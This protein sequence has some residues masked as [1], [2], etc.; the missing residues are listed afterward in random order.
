MRPDVSSRRTEQGKWSWQQGN[1]AT[2]GKQDSMEAHD[3][4][5]CKRCCVSA[6]QLWS[7]LS[8]DR[9]C[10]WIKVQ[11]FFFILKQRTFLI[12]Q[13]EWKVTLKANEKRIVKLG[14]CHTL[15]HCQ[16]ESCSYHCHQDPGRDTFRYILFVVWSSK[17]AVK[18]QFQWITM[19]TKGELL[20]SAA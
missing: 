15:M 18:R 17:D 5:G 16:G 12:V 19:S 1:L 11:D 10:V 7:D 6:V 8:V 4:H 9:A 14:L 13:Q 3:G 20:E 2:N